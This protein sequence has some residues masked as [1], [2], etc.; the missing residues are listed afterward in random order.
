MW[1]KKCIRRYVKKK[2]RS[3]VSLSVSRFFGTKRTVQHAS[4]LFELRNS[5][6]NFPLNGLAFASITFSVRSLHQTL[7]CFLVL[8]APE[9]RKRKKQEAQATYHQGM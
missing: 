6:P 1:P 9:K 5:N 7:L 3:A 8:S 2:T 4:Q